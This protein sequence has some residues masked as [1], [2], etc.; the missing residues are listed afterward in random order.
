MRKSSIITA[1]VTGMFMTAT[2]LLADYQA[3]LAAYRAKDYKKAL[4]E[5]KATPTR[6]SQYIRYSRSRICC[7]GKPASFDFKPGFRTE[8]S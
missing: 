7:P 1:V 2:P 3:G 4:K 8:L 6:D 5:F